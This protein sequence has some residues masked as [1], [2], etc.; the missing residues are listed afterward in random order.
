MVR[1]KNFTTRNCTIFFTLS[2]TPPPLLCLF[3]VQLLWR[4]KAGNGGED[5]RARKVTALVMVC[6]CV[7][8][9]VDGRGFIRRARV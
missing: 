3:I 5:D 2:S 9:M 4:Q 6:E 8:L 7:W 1:R